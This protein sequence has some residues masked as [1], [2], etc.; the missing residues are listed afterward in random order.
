[1]RNQRQYYQRIYTE[2]AAAYDVILESPDL[3]R[4]ALSQFVNEWGW[5]EK[6]A[7]FQ[8][9]DEQRNYIVASIT[10]EEAKTIF[11]PVRQAEVFK[12]VSK[13]YVDR[14]DYRLPFQSVLIQ[15][16]SPLTVDVPVSGDLKPDK[17]KAFLLRQTEVTPELIRRLQIET[18]EFDKAPPALREF[19]PE[20][21]PGLTTGMG[22]HLIMIFE[23]DNIG[24]T[25]WISDSQYELVAG[26]DL[27]TEVANYWLEMKRL[28][29]ACIGYINCENVYLHR[30]GEV[31][32]KVNRKREKK[33]KSRLEPYYVC[34]IRGVNYESVATGEGAKHGIRYD[35]RGHFRRMADGRTTWVRSHQRGLANELYVPKVY[36]VEPSRVE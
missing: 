10:A 28:A 4:Q 3:M 16:D 33:G 12:K 13:D 15:F 25:K 2:R 35:V 17:L 9:Q 24:G 27:L 23:D 18:A 20:I 14:L 1:M 11:F 36:K 26:D 30:E 8:M 34:R 22:N 29:I 21:A 19:L 5:G 7:V 32:E 31:S 6:D